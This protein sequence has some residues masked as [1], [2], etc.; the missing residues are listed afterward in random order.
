MNYKAAQAIVDK[1][2]KHEYFTKEPI[3]L[4]EPISY[5]LENGGKR[6]RPVLTLMAH[7]VFASGLNENIVLTALGLEILHNFTLLH[8]DIMDKA[9]VR[10]GKPTVHLKWDENT[11]ILSGDAM[12]IKAYEYIAKCEPNYLPAVLKEFSKVGLEICEG[13]QYDMDFETC[14]N[15]SIDEYLEMIRL[16][17]AVLLGSSLKI[18]AV[19]GGA[20]KENSELIYQFGLNI[21]MAFQL[22]DDIL[23]VYANF[24]T[25][26]KE[27]GGDISSNKKTFLLL[28]A[29]ELAKGTIKERLESLIALKKFDKNEKYKA[30]RAIYDK[31]G[32]RLEA[33]KLM[34]F[35]YESAIKALDKVSGSDEA[36]KE[37]KY[38]ADSL[39]KRTK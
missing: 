30:V 37:L 27:P 18:G 32:V 21:G 24:E 8:D 13:Q 26:G 33:E 17:T 6:I 4:Y 25:F 29:L 22:M 2:L 36:K 35:Y 10:R 9:E 7:S 1:Q 15:V 38:L 28:K 39:M 31:L 23:D 5:T 11:A 19:C 16:K 12:L 34:E 3:G 14:D 20:S